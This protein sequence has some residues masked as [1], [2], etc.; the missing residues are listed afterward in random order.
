MPAI[1]Q[2]KKTTDVEGLAA[3]ATSAIMLA[4]LATLTSRRKNI[5]TRHGDVAPGLTKANPSTPTF[6]AN[7]NASVPTDTSIA[8][9]TSISLHCITTSATRSAAIVSLYFGTA[10]STPDLFKWYV[11]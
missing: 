7:G 1:R 10:A 3:S 11:Y 4:G 8:S 5:V 6:P 9:F 2:S